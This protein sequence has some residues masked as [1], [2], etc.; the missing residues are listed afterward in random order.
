MCAVPTCRPGSTS[1]EIPIEQYRLIFM[2]NFT[3]LVYPLNIYAS[4]LSREVKE[5]VWLHYGHFTCPDESIEKAQDRAVG[6]I[7]VH[8]PQHGRILEAGCG[9]GKLTHSLA[10]LGYEVTGIT[11]DHSQYKIALELYGSDLP[12][13]CTDLENFAQSEGDWD[14]LLFHES[15]QYIPTLKLFERASRLLKPGGQILILD[16]FAI[17]RV[18]P[19]HE[20]LHFKTHFVALAKRFGFTCLKEMDYTEAAAPTL[21]F[22]ISSLQRD[23]DI[24]ASEANVSPLEIDDLISSNRQYKEKYR[25]GRFGYFLLVFEKEKTPRWRLGQIEKKDQP[26]VSTLFKKV[27]NQQLSSEM[28]NWKYGNDRGRAIGLWEGKELVAHYGGVNRKIQI[29]DAIFIASQSCD[30]MVQT[31]VRVAS[32]QGPYFQVCATFF[33]QFAGYGTG[34]PLSFGFPNETAFRLPHRLGL[35]SDPL[36]RISELSWQTKTVGNI[37]HGVRTLD[38]NN[39]DHTAIIDLLWQKM[40]GQLPALAVGV[41]DADYW[42]QRYFTHPQHSYQ[43]VLVYHR[44]FR[45]PV[46][47]AVVKEDGERLELLD[48]VSAIKDIPA[49]IN[50]LKRF[51]AAAGYQQFYTQVSTQVVEYMKLTSPHEKCLNIL[52]PTNAW[53]ESPSEKLLMNR[54]WLTGGDTDFR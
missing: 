11:P 54:L 27:F 40:I 5:T 38:L 39:D 41:R 24:L 23:R 36:T 37:L 7:C 25:I 10:L 52:I 45:K 33:E 21:D 14:I 29:G 19:A 34:F 1:V 32:R 2:S 51:S 48:W 12:V 20:N 28:W 30:A 35:V 49:L 8:L 46:A 44:L 13:Q 26:A 22:L 17:K 3:K 43:I 50:A 47:V 4:I 53:T 15:G 6:N 18:E 31:T 9:L 16:E 42:R